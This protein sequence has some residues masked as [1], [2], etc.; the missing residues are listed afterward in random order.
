MGMEKEEKRVLTLD[1]YEHGIIIHALNDMRND[2]LDEDRPTDAVDEVL[3]KTIDAPARKVRFGG[4]PEKSG[5]FLGE[6]GAT[7]H[8]SFRP[9]GAKRTERSLRRRD[10][11]AR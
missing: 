4:V 8:V 6:G 10:D 7:E 2:L 5:G 3:L 9:E 11:E 1:K